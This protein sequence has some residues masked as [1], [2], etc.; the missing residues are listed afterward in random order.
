M[1]T[2]AKVESEI[3]FWQARLEA[4]ETR[5]AGDQGI[6]AREID[7]V[8]ARLVAL[9]RVCGLIAPETSGEVGFLAGLLAERTVE[10]ERDH[11]GVAGKFSLLTK[12]AANIRSKLGGTAGDDQE[13]DGETL[14]A[15]LGKELE[16]AWEEH[17]ALDR[18]LIA[19]GCE[20][21]AS[22]EP[23]LQIQISRIEDIE[24]A[25]AACMPTSPS[26]AAFLGKLLNYEI[27]DFADPGETALEGRKRLNVTLMVTSLSEFLSGS[28]ETSSP[29]LPPAYRVKRRSA[30]TL[31]RE[32]DPAEHTGRPH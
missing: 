20:G 21:L 17:S 3:H 18:E 6:W 13:T 30:S 10:I 32:A 15:A 16:V 2:I 14:I 27:A 8:V 19:K 1:G 26:D 24:D 11:L 5:A 28:G 25:I 22:I 31:R 12:L 9:E 23:Q 7:T 4:I 29:S